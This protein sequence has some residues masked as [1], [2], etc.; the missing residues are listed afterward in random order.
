[1]YNPKTQLALERQVLEPLTCG[2]SE[3]HRLVEAIFIRSVLCWKFVWKKWK[4]HLPP[5]RWSET[6]R[7]GSVRRHL[8]LPLGRQGP[9]HL[10]TL[11]HETCYFNVLASRFDFEHCELY[12]KHRLQLKFEEI[13]WGKQALYKTK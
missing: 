10:H 7:R 13:R 2:A 11:V 4:F 3:L 12:H 1:M 6:E 8:L 5:W 9:V